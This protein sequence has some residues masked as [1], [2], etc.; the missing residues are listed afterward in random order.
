MNYDGCL[1]VRRATWRTVTVQCARAAV[2]SGCSGHY[3]VLAVG[4]VP[5]LIGFFSS[6]DYQALRPHSRD[7]AW[8]QGWCYT[9]VLGGATVKKEV[10]PRSVFDDFVAAIAGHNVCEYMPAYK[11]RARR[12]INHNNAV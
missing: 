4:P 11:S 9:H 10:H 7:S 12:Y 8:G 6:A 3:P 2:P 5:N 1:R